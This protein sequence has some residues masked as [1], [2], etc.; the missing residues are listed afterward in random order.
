MPNPFMYPKQ[1]PRNQTTELNRTLRIFKM[2]SSFFIAVVAILWVTFAT[3]VTSQSSSL[4]LE[5]LLKTGWWNN[6]NLDM[7]SSCNWLGIACDEGGS[8]TKIDRRYNELKGSIPPEIG[9]FSKLTHLDLSYNYV[10]GEL[11]ISLARLTQLKELLLSNNQITGSIPPEISNLENLVILDLSFNIL[12]GPIPL[13]FK[14]PGAFIGNK[15]LCGDI[16][17]FPP[18]PRPTKEKKLFLWKILLPINIFLA[19][20]FFGY[21]F[22]RMRYIFPALKFSLM[23]QKIQCEGEGR[24]TKNGDLFSIWTFDGKIAYEDI[25]NATEDFNIKYCIGMGSCGSLYKAQL[26]SGKVVA[27]KKL[28]SIEAHVPGITKSFQNEIKILTNIR[29]RNIVRLHG[30]CVHKRCNF[31]IYE[32]MERRNLYGVL[33]SDVE[34]KELTW[35]IRVNI[36]RGIA[37]ALSYMH[38]DSN[39]SIIH[40]DIT[41]SNI[42]LNSELEAFV[43]DFGMARFNDPTSSNPTKLAGTHGYM[44]PGILFLTNVLLL[45]SP[46]YCVFFFLPLRD[47]WLCNGSLFNTGII[48]R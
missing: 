4:E 37:H 30:Y 2:V 1:E 29:H 6:T 20:L 7:S 46:K 23:S 9:N 8:V 31:L 47:K 15:D 5:A 48:R 17:G 24:A 3:T 35:R 25:I 18:C 27:L 10:S 22:V 44:A 13:G 26:P 45:I 16:T 11:P 36:I 34:A 40:R 41:S 19:V 43:A 14:S 39:P 33:S 28:H 21:L 12:I 32:Y 42:L 38:H